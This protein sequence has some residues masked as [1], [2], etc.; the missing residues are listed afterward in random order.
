MDRDEFLQKILPDNSYGVY[1]ATTTFIPRGSDKPVFFNRGFDNVSDLAAY[2]AAQSAKGN[3]AFFALGTFQ[4]NCEVD[5]N[6]K[7]HWR[8]TA[9]M[10]TA[11]KVFALD[12][13]CGDGKPYPDQRAGAAA[14]GEFLRATGLSAPRIVSSG[15]GL[16]CYW[17]IEET[18]PK[19][20]WVRLARLF[21]ELTKLH[22][23][24]VDDSKVCD[25]TMVYRPLDTTNWKRSGAVPVKLLR[26]TQPI[27]LSLFVSKL[28]TVSYATKPKLATKITASPLDA[29]YDSFAKDFPPSDPARVVMK[30]QQLRRIVF[31]H[32]ENATEPEWY[33]SLGIA[34]YCENPEK[35]AVEWSRGHA[36]FTPDTT[37]A[38]M[39]H[40]REASGG[41]TTC[42]RFNEIN[43]NGCTGCK[44][45]NKIT[46]PIVLGR[47]EPKPVAPSD[48]AT[49]PH[50]LI[51]PPRPYTR[52][53]EG[54]VATVDDVT[55]PVC[56]YD[57]FPVQIVFDPAT[58]YE[59]A[60]FMWNKP[61][62]G[63]ITLPVRMS[64]LFAD[65]VTDLISTLSDA[66][67]L[68]SGKEQQKRVGAYMRAY[69]QSLQQKMATTELYTSFGWKDDCNAFVIGRTEFRKEGAREIGIS[70]LLIDRRLDKAYTPKGS[71]ETW[72]AWTKIFA[73][74][75]LAGHGFALGVAFAAPLVQF[76]ALKGGII[77]LV[78]DSGSGKTTMQRMVQSVYGDPNILELKK[79]DT[80]PAIMQ[81]M[82]MLSH[83]PVTIDEVTLMEGKDFAKVNYW[84]TQ[85][86]DR[87]RQTDVTTVNS[88]A[89]LTMVSSNKSMREAQFAVAPG[90]DALSMRVIEFTINRN[91]IFADNNS[92]GKRLA[93]MMN[94]NYGHAGR[95]YIEYLVKL[96]KDELQRR[97]HDQYEAFEAKYGV[98]FPGKER[99]WFM[100]YA[101]VDLGLQLAKEAGVILFDAEPCTRWA[102]DKLNSQRDSVESGLFTPYDMLAT[103]INSNIDTAVTVEYANGKARVPLD[104]PMR[105]CFIRKEIYR[106]GKDNISGGFLYIDRAHFRTW[107]AERKWDYKRIMDTF[108]Y[109]GVTHSPNRYN[110]I[111]MGK[112]TNLRLGQVPVL[113]LNL[114]DGKLMHMLNLTVAPVAEAAAKKSPSA[115]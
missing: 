53:D 9:E 5:A 47:P 98:S 84:A 114:T 93:F 28:S 56:S 42:A 88:W 111:T 95:R 49:V 74:Q 77:S 41:P 12:I 22:G 96:G 75:E 86:S 64:F 11:F 29:A 71:E 17:P 76:T 54:I 105:N 85:G 89:T 81:R 19:D 10:A 100:I 109:D 83:L 82:G 26:E 14:L 7:E 15:Y 43:T 37:I 30:C 38:K 31:N 51:E 106:D 69:I 23:L 87:N 101:A 80:L 102:V 63:Y 97:W 108:N 52:T 68:V 78:G 45:A 67:F 25:A 40:W 99:Y 94:D 91:N 55:V 2:C 62:R 39:Q 58:G 48:D 73:H 92:Y 35:T 59:A 27:P 44:F 36:D 46:S 103:Y 112:D 57:L 20:E 107:A 1:V 8:R 4:N 90:D 113:G 18:I 24:R 72:K 32:G 61:H 6:G 79:E 65:S 33:A 16:H 50:P 110:K 34:A 60:L 70:K 21:R 13:D 104:Q 66:G 3:T 115:A